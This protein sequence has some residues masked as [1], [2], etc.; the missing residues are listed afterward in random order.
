M[1]RIGMRLE[2]EASDE[3]YAYTLSYLVEQASKKLKI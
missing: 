2:L 3:A 1:D